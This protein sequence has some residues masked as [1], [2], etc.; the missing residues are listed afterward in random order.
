MNEINQ[1]LLEHYEL[2]IQV[3][4]QSDEAFYT[5][6]GCYADI[7]YDKEICIFIGGGGSIDFV[8]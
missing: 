7:D 1:Y 2:Q 8:C 3:V 4:S 6:Y 5:A